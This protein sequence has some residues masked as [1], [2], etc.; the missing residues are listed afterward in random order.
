MTGNI[1]GR[2]GRGVATVDLI[3]RGDGTY[4][5]RID[6]STCVA[7]EVRVAGVP[8]QK[9]TS[10]FGRVS[11]YRHAESLTKV[12][13]CKGAEGWV[14]T[15]YGHGKHGMSC[16]IFGEGPMVL[17]LNLRPRGDGSFVLSGYLPV[18]LVAKIRE[19]GVNVTDK[20]A[21]TKPGAARVPAR[22]A[23]EA[24]A[25]RLSPSHD[26]EVNAARMRRPRGPPSVR[27]HMEKRAMKTSKLPKVKR[28]S[29]RNKPKPDDAVRYVLV[30]PG[31]APIVASP[32]IMSDLEVFQKAVGGLVEEV[33][34][35]PHLEGSRRY[36]ML[37]NDAGLLRSLP[38][39]RWG[40]VGAFVVVGQG[41][42]D[43]RGLTEDEANAIVEHLGPAGGMLRTSGPRT[44]EGVRLV[45]PECIA[46]ADD[47]VASGG[48]W[49]VDL[50]YTGT[51]SGNPKMIAALNAA[52][53]IYAESIAA[54]HLMRC[55]NI[56]G[57]FSLE[58]VFVEGQDD[59]RRAFRAF[60]EASAG[61]EYRANEAAG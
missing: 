25:R 8:L 2:D 45:V 42:D 7:A 26:G 50:H 19:A 15:D 32:A 28:P 60:I 56:P 21:P 23:P 24:Q 39:N 48:N 12:M 31:E 35:P 53:P 52:L 40:I 46:H 16:V 27:T 11:I 59:A 9:L 18:W 51:Y 36:V 57:T 44:L 49:N 13:R 3:P 6:V 37:A 34:Y 55:F 5:A 17:G 43:W 30:R 14:P 22:R 1:H 47:Y 41:G 33:P 61:A 4:R 58:L 29:E 38:A 20:P 10:P 54:Y